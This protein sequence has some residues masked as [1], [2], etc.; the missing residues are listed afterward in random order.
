MSLVEA[1]EVPE[2]RS[3]CSTSTTRKPRPAAS[4]AIP[5]PL[6]PPPTMARSKSAMLGDSL[7]CDHATACAILLCFQIKCELIVSQRSAARIL[8]GAGFAVLQNSPASK[9]G[10]ERRKAH[11]LPRADKLAQSAHADCVGGASL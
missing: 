9:R 4:R 10:A 11:Q 5:A 1:D 3:F 7:R 8:C 2:A 6:M